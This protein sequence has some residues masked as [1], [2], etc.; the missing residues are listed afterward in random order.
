MSKTKK[1][2]PLPGKKELRIAVQK[3]REPPK[4]VLAYF[5][6]EEHKDILIAEKSR[7]IGHRRIYVMLF[8]DKEGLSF[9]GFINTQFESIGL[10][11]RENKWR[12]VFLEQC[13]THWD[14]E[15]KSY[16]KDYE[17]LT[18]SIGKKFFSYDSSDSSYLSFKHFLFNKIDNKKYIDRSKK[19]RANMI[20]REEAFNAQYRPINPSF[21]RWGYRKLRSFG[22]FNLNDRYTCT[23]KDCGTSF[24]TEQP[25]KNKGEVKCPHCKRNL[26]VMTEKTL[27]G[28]DEIG[29]QYLDTDV[30]G[31]LVVRHFLFERNLA[32]GKRSYFE[33][34]R[35]PFPGKKYVFE[36]HVKRWNGTLYQYTWY[37]NKPI[38]GACRLFQMR[39]I[40]YRDEYL[41]RGNI[42]ELSAQYPQIIYSGLTAL[43]KSQLVRAEFHLY[44][45]VLAPNVVECLAKMG[46]AN[47]VI[48]S[49]YSE[50]NEYSED[51]NAKRLFIGLKSEYRNA[52][53][54]YSELSIH[55]IPMIHQA[56]RLNVSPEEL[57]NMMANCRHI[58][59]EKNWYYSG[60]VVIDFLSSCEKYNVSPH[61][62]FRYFTDRG[63]DYQL[64]LDYAKWSV[65]VLGAD[66]IKRNSL[67]VANL[68]AAHDRMF[69]TYEQSILQDSVSLREMNEKCIA[70][71]QYLLDRHLSDLNLGN[72]FGVVVPKDKI[73][74]ALEG[75]RMHICVGGDSYFRN[76][77]NGES[78][79]FFLRQAESMEK[80]FACCEATLSGGKLILKQCRMHHNGTPPEK[81]E[82]AAKKYISKLNKVLSFENN[83]ISYNVAA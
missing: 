1:P 59:K 64:W 66:K 17:F 10:C 48:K 73:D 46:Y 24:K 69:R 15:S 29:C 43:K 14:K 79:V 81:V 58:A 50:L 36:H 30:L 28:I 21:I 26:V 71:Y 76:H 35:N 11:V 7:I 37:H 77:V 56:Q 20:A 32:T 44:K 67:L 65:A 13:K 5:S 23:C 6:G 80:S 16:V 55:D 31:N 49:H 39:D 75:H 2:L 83:T 54:D 63:N 3:Y 74:F 42:K 18:D 52:L 47:L 4:E 12:A 62:A 34:E 8:Y 78:L 53:K 68:Y 57:K 72:G 41:Y 25:I 33:Y 82:I 9:V 51:T 70:L 19:T 22:L 40:F 61:K 60:T 38:Q 27:P 45:W